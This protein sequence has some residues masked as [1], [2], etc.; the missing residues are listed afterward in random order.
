MMRVLVAC[1]F[2]GAVRDAFAARGHDAWS[3]DLRASERP[4]QH[5][6]GDALAAIAAGGWDLLIAHPPCTYLAN[7][8]NK[9]LYGGGGPIRDARR[10]AAMETGARFFRACLDA[11]VPRV[12]VENPI[13]HR[14]AREIIGCRQTQII[15]PWQFGH[16][17]C[18][19]TCLWLRGLPPLRPTQIVAGRE[20][21]VHRM[22]PGPNRQKERAR[23]YSGIAAAMAD[24]WGAAPSIISEAQ[25]LLPNITR[26]PAL[27]RE[28]SGG[29][30]DRRPQE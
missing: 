18:K 5:I 26:A 15:Q 16:G 8:S 22:S 3:C 23:T 1:E 29:P 4:G 14:H 30:L 13:I 27:F 19:A 10:W 20:Q 2:S 9:W 25:L 12:A 24:Q 21:R 17:E 28:R 6:Q 11:D 7:S